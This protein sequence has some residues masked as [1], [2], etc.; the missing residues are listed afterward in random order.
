MP[1]FYKWDG[2]ALVETKH[3][4]Y[5]AI[6]D[7]QNSHSPINKQTLSSAKGTILTD[8]NNKHGSGDED[9][10]FW[11]EDDKDNMG[12]FDSNGVFH[13]GSAMLPHGNAEFEEKN[14]IFSSSTIFQGGEHRR[15][16]SHPNSFL[17]RSSF[18]PPPSTPT[19]TSTSTHQLHHWLYKD[20]T[21]KVQ[22]P[23]TAFEMQEWFDAGYFNHSLKIKRDDPLVLLFNKKTR[24]YC[25]H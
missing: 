11:I 9:V 6:N 1:S 24:G 8:V 10:P 12:T 16:V 3:H 19:S 17:N 23:F 13:L 25:L 14:D 18:A 21:G 7:S 2:K 22:G 5:A 4:K 20:P 15:A